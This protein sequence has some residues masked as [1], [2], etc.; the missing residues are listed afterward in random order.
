MTT[1]DQFGQAVRCAQTGRLTEAQALCEQVLRRDPR[2]PRALHLLG[3]LA[4]Q[5]GRHE[6]ALDLLGRALQV[7][8]ANAA[9]AYDLALACCLLGRYDQAAGYFV[10]TLALQPGHVEALLNLGNVE[11][12]RGRLD[13]AVRCYQR[14][15]AMRPDLAAAHAN[16]GLALFRAGRAEEAAA[17]FR[18]QLALQP[19]AGDGHLNLGIVLNHLGRGDEALASLERARGLNPVHPLVHYQVGLAHFGRG[20]LTAS[21]AAFERAAALKADYVEA[22]VNRA[23][24][25]IRLERPEEAAVSCQRALAI[26][27]D[28]PEAHLTLALARQ[29][30]GRLEEA[31]AAAREALACRPDYVEACTNLVTLYLDLGRPQ[32]AIVSGERAVALRPD[33]AGAHYN[34]GLAYYG[35]SRLDEAVASYRRALALMPDYA[36]ALVN[37]GLAYVQLGRCEEALG[38]FDRALTVAPDLA[39]AHSA[40]LLSMH[41]RVETTPA[42]ALAAHRRFAGRCEAPLRM[43]WAPHVNPRDPARRLKVGYV[44]GD[45]RRHSVAYFLLPILAHHDRTQVEVFAYHNHSQRDDVTDLIAAEVDHWV[46]CAAWTDAELAARVRAD[47]ID[48]L[49]DLSGHTEGNRLLAFAR[50]PAPVQVTYLGY[51]GST[52]LAA[53]DYRLCSWDTDPAG[54][55][56]WHS[57]RLYRLPRSLWCFRPLLEAGD[58]PAVAR[59]AA[60]GGGFV[61]GSMNAFPKLSPEVLDVWGEILRA[62]PAARLVMTSVPEGETRDALRRRFADWGIAADRLELH[63]R[64]PYFRYRELLQRID[65][66]LDPFPYNGTTTT[67]DTLWRGIPVVSRTGATSVARSGHALLKAVGLEALAVADEAAYVTTAV[68]LAGD[69]ARLAALRAGLRARFEASPLRDEAGFTREIEA[70]YRAMW[71]EWCQAGRS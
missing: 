65:V 40:R 45:L 35:Q 2:H 60:T 4:R 38:C 8:A 1:E 22:H 20:E 21:L 6:Q 18:R 28:A 9:V 13:E 55:E 16:L 66:A 56:A 41:Y 58:D 44:S 50:K 43:Q 49:V 25:L 52:G 30:Q 7:D 68:E 11:L 34:L 62:A 42:E 46:P 61:F 54:A 64:L 15:L 57:E 47:G 23:N 36:E 33:L 32:D 51:A 5:A 70:A 31:L 71:R 27:P 24:V 14:A 59:H 37:L 69:P 39:Q 48:I 10:Q 17:A 3:V 26:R 67:C 19:H 53:M 63:G 12:A 29:R